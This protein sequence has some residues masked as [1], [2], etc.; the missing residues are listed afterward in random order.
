MVVALVSPAVGEEQR[1]EQVEQAREDLGR[2]V[3]REMY[4]WGSSAQV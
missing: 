2:S 3:Q 4:G 1:R